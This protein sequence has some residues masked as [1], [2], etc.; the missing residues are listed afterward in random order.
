M[1]SRVRRSFSGYFNNCSLHAPIASA[2]Q[3]VAITDSAASF[4]KELPDFGL[5]YNQN[6]KSDR[7]ITPTS[8]SSV[9][10]VDN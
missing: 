6:Q 7:G 3:D 1:G 10:A 5:N 9:L 2:A 8:S 4:N